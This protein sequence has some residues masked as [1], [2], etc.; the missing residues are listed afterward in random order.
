MMIK[1][2]LLM[3]LY[4]KEKPQYLNRCLKSINDLTVSPAE[5]VFVKDGPLTVELDEII[6]SFKS[7]ADIK[8]ISL[9]ENVTLGPA[10]AAGVEAAGN[11][12]IAIMDC[13]DLCKPDRFEKQLSMIDKN[14]ALGLIGG[15]IV[16][17]GG[18]TRA[19]P[20]EHDDIVRFSKKRNPFNHMTVMFKREAVL[21]AGNY[22]LFP[23]FEDYDLWTRMISNGTICAN[24]SD[25]L[26]DVAVDRNTY[27]RRRGAGY[28]RLEWRMQKQLKTL[29]LIGTAGFLRNIIIRIPVRLLPGGILKRI[30]RVFARKST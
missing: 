16:E 15:Q 5:I 14:P 17:S 28:I 10:R 27:G 6:N 1:F 21:S 4:E 23:W 25:I 8:I 9:P 13:D 22:R 3:C 26:V 7:S 20:L 18:K 30:Y 12:W 24:H 29:G 19:V 11:E 2:S